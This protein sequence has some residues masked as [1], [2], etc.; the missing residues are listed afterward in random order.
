MSHFV[1]VPRDKIRNLCSAI[2]YIIERKQTALQETLNAEDESPFRKALADSIFLRHDLDD[3]NDL[4]GLALDCAPEDIKHFFLQYDE[5][6][7][8]C[9]F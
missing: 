7:K 3:L 2:H 5:I 1:A 6:R 4:F 8:A 9:P